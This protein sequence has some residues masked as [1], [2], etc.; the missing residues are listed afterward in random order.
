MNQFHVDGLFSDALR[1]Q[2]VSQ[3]AK[4]SPV[5]KR[6]RTRVWLGTGALAGAG[7]LGAGAAAAGL[8]FI[9]G[10]EKVTP[11]AS[12]VT[13]TYTGTATV[14]LGNPPEG[15]TGIQMELRFLTPGWF[16]F[17][18]GASSSCSEEDVASW[19][20]YT[21][22]LAPGQ[23]SVPRKGP[24]PRQITVA[25]QIVSVLTMSSGTNQRSRHQ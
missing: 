11:L 7:L 23:D 22:S 25:N 4:E 21:I 16:E 24:C 12:P 2:L 19:S 13:T 18:D 9:P 5:A 1:A 6:R 8:F 10:S 14:E 17:P 15:T 3:V 20:G